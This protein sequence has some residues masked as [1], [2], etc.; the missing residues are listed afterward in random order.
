M[1]IIGSLCRWPISKS[2]K[3][4][5]GVTLTAPVPNSMSTSLASPMIGILRPVSGSSTSLPISC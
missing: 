3:S 5:A 2:L 1:L 4:C